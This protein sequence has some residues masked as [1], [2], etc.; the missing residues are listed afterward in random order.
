MQ[1]ACPA[2]LLRVGRQ[3]QD[4]ARITARTRYQVTPP[5]DLRSGISGSGLGL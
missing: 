2:L 1:G 4:N 5:P 3:C